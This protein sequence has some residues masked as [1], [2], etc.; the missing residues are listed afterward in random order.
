MI[1][2]GDEDFLEMIIHYGRKDRKTI[3]AV[4]VENGYVISAGYGDPIARIATTVL[5]LNAHIREMMAPLS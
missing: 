2:L 1:E 3:R 4:R 5:E